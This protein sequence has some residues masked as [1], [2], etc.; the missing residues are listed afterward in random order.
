MRTWFERI[1]IARPAADTWAVV[2]DYRHDV[3][4]RR[5]VTAMVP[6]PAGMA[7]T[8][9]RTHE[10]GRLLGSPFETRGVVVAAD[11]HQFRWEATGVGSRASG[12]RE[13]VALDADRCEVVLG[14]SVRLT[15]RKAALNPVF[16]A[17]FR[18]SVRRNLRALKRQ[19]EAAQPRSDSA[20]SR[21]A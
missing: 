5:E 14:Y 7:A 3:E 1:E 20:S 10:T 18:R 13:V 8:G 4:W 2:G 12:S 21:A 15:G 9:T 6:A 16:V 17:A 19:L 11:G